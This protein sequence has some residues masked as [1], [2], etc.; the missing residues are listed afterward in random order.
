MPH[1]HVWF[2]WDKWVFI[3]H[4]SVLFVRYFLV[5]CGW[6]T[7]QLGQKLIW[8]GRRSN[9]PRNLKARRLSFCSP[10]SQSWWIIQGICILCTM[11]NFQENKNSI[12]PSIIHGFTKTPILGQ[13]QTGIGI[14][15][16]SE[17]QYPPNSKPYIQN[18]FPYKITEYHE[19]FALIAFTS[20]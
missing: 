6:L 13:Y 4:V 15:C 14:P 19:P 9:M 3:S 20:T 10:F 2:H 17:L 18:T 11:S 1:F 12:H 7:R 16:I 5:W 8:S